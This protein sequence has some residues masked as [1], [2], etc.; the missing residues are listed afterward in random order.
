MTAPTDDTLLRLSETTLTVADPREDV[1]GRKV[2]DDAG[3]EIGT[4][5]D[6]LVDSKEHRVR[7]LKVSH[8]GF[9]GIGADHFLVPVD[10]VGAV[11]DDAVRLDRS[12]SALGSAPGYDPQV[13]EDRGY[14]DA[15]YG[16]WGYP[17]YWGPGYIAPLFPY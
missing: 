8:G 17:A 3:E 11:T 9:L 5:D 10:A 12:R 15:V 13:E 14:Y 7:M 2:L 1:R 6:L 4:V 16:W